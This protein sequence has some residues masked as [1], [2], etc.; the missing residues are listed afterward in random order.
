MK[1]LVLVVFSWAGVAGSCFAEPPRTVAETTDYKA[2]SRH[3]D[4]MEFCAKLTKESPLVR[5]GEMGTSFEGRK[6][7]LMILADP[8]IATAAEAKVVNARRILNCIIHI[9]H[10]GIPR[11]YDEY[12]R[13]PRLKSAA[14]RGTAV[15]ELS[16]LSYSSDTKP[17][18]P[19]CT[20]MLNSRSQSAF[21]FVPSSPAIRSLKCTFTA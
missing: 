8:P 2:T 21:A 5:L 19:P 13:T 16:A 7:P 15:S 4:V 18:Y 3:A 17:L 6:L 9:I 1:R 12:F 11:I 14:N 10:N 20:N